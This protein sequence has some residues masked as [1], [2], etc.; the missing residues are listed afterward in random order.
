MTTRAELGGSD[1]EVGSSVPWTLLWDGSSRVRGTGVS[2]LKASDAP[3]CGE[4][5]T[6]GAEA[7]T[8]AGAGIGAKLGAEEEE[9]DEDDSD[10]G[11]ST[12]TEDP[13]DVSELNVWVAE[14]A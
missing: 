7:G 4:D 12:C 3:V 9:L 11:A 14:S 8:E 10:G 13:L 2:P 1:K 5:S 6:G